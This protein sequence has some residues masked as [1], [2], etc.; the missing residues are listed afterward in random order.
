MF[1]VYSARACQKR[2]ERRNEVAFLPHAVSPGENGGAQR[3]TTAVVRKKG[4]G[5]L[6]DSNRWR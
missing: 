3:T 6:L 1:R 2:P 5:N 4:G